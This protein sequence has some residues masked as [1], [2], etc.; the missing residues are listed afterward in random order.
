MSKTYIVTDYFKPVDITDN[1]F[2][3]GVDIGCKY[4]MEAGI[5]P[6]VALGDF[7]SM[8]K[9]LICQLPDTTQI[10]RYN[11]IKAKSD[12]ELAI[13]F[14]IAN[15]MNEIVLLNSLEGRF[16]HIVGVINNLVYA[17]KKGLDITVISERVTAFLIDSFKDLTGYPG[18]Y[19]S[20]YA[21]D[22]DAEGVY[23][24][25]FKYPLNDAILPAFSCLGL[26]NEFQEET[27]TVEV[28]KGLLL[29]IIE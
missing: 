16:G 28:R 23:L 22:N 25:G 10:M 13:E 5:S 9:E 7:D 26:S 18:T 21:L 29:C 2:V 15:K 17:Y 14:C 19:M 27:R 24:K 1:D 11:P 20:L 8:P 12:T 3:I 4:L 6:N